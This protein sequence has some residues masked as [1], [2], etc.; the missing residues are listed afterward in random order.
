MPAFLCEKTKAPG[1]LL[2]NR[3][4]RGCSRVPFPAVRGNYTLRA[5]SIL[6]PC[7]GGDGATKLSYILRRFQSTRPTLNI[8]EKRSL[9]LGHIRYFNTLPFQVVRVQDYYTIGVRKFLSTATFGRTT[10]PWTCNGLQFF[11]KGTAR[12]DYNQQS[13][14]Q[15]GG[16]LLYGGFR[17]KGV[18]LCGSRNR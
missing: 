5:I 14:L 13:T 3:T 4:S 17:R 18:F 16:Y 1:Y 7:D 2:K 6:A 11:R 9:C 8:T 12:V 10:S 15:S